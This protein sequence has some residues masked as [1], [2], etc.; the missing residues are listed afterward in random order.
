MQLFSAFSL[1]LVGTA[2]VS[3][4]NRRFFRWPTALAVMAIALVLSLGLFVLEWCGCGL[5]AWGEALPWAGAADEGP[6]LRYVLFDG[7]LAF[8]LFAA[9]LHVDLGR[10]LQQR[11]VIVALAVGGVLASAVVVPLLVV[12]A[13]RR[14][15]L[16]L[17]YAA[18]LVLGALAAPTEALALRAILRHAGA[19]HV[20]ETRVAGEALGNAALGFVVFRLA[21]GLAG[22]AEHGGN[23]PHGFGGV[24]AFFLWGVPGG[25]ALGLVCGWAT[26]RLLR[27]ADD[28]AVELLLTL[29]LSTGLYSLCRWLHASGPLALCAAGLF[30]GNA[31]RSWAVPGRTGARLEAF[32]ELVSTLLIA[33]LLV[34]LGL[35]VLVARPEQQVL[36]LGALAV[37]SVLLARL[38]GT[39]GALLTLRG[40]RRGALRSSLLLTWGGLRGGVAAALVLSL[41]P[42]LPGRDLV[43]VLAFVVVACSILLQGLT[44]GWVARR[45]PKTG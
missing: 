43:L 41:P 34:L 28:Q 33:V 22:G 30:L 21:L 26:Y 12:W 9:A 44:L 1:V 36:L 31:G 19:G 13:A 15:G 27:T 10:L 5:R 24:L 16:E 40:A 2:L 45:L 38:L 20:L 25:V 11:R 18:A 17:G 37:P 4:L 32:W 29:A 14:M 8:L 42:A 23:A 6:G 7:L 39:G 35:E 3:T